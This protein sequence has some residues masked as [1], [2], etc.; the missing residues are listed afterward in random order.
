MSESR[1]A[2][3]RLVRRVSEPEDRTLAVA[4]GT[5][6]Q[7]GHQRDGSRFPAIRSTSTTERRL[8]ALED[9]V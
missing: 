3:R 2:D 5:D 9:L 4:E 6:V 7:Y 8:A 1:S